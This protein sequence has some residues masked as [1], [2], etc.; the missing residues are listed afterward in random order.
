MKNGLTQN[1]A[2]NGAHGAL[3]MMAKLKMVSQMVSHPFFILCS[4][5]R[6]ECYFHENVTQDIPR[7]EACSNATLESN[8]DVQSQE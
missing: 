2:K 8:I 4:R 3:H 1:H 6:R 7:T 5:E